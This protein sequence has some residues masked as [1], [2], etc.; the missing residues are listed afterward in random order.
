MRTLPLSRPVE[1][2][3]SCRTDHH[4]PAEFAKTALQLGWLM[5]DFDDAIL[6][7]VIEAPNLL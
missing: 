2:V 4:V 7:T 5:E 6:S 3:V 1:E